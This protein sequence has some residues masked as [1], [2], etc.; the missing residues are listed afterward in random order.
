MSDGEVLIAVV[1]DSSCGR[2]NILSDVEGSDDPAA[3][4]LDA[5][6]MLPGCSA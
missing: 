6:S 5:E 2:E 4:L 3:V 1:F